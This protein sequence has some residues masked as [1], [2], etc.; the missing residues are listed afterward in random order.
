MVYVEV[1]KAVEEGRGLLH[2]T[3][4]WVSAQAGLRTVYG[5]ILW[6]AWALHA[7]APRPPLAT[8]PP[9]AILPGPDGQPPR[10]S[11]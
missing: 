7:D 10:P 6:A 3:L 8:D 1:K 2:S 9:A 5:L 4:W 11:A